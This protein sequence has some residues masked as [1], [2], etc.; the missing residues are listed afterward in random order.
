[1]VTKTEH[2]LKIS[3]ELFCSISSMATISACLVPFLNWFVR[4]CPLPIILFLWTITQPTGT[5]KS[6]FAFSAFEI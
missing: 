2:S 6:N 3:L 1:M 4:L 5:S